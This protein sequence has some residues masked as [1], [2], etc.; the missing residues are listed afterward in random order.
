MRLVHGLRGRDALCGIRRQQSETAE[1]GI[2]RAAQAIVEPHF[3]GAGRQLVDGSTGGSVDD[4]VVGLLDENLLALGIGEQP[5]V[6][7]R[8]DDG[9]GER[10]AGRGNRVDRVGR[11]GVIVVG[12]F[13]DRILEAGP[14]GPGTANSHDQEQR[15]ADR[16]K[17]V[18]NIS[19]HWMTP[20]GVVEKA[21]TLPPSPMS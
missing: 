20:A 4:L 12:E 2:D 21:A 16:A 5:V 14:Q 3:G 8:A 11:V 1:R 13:C 10:I 15:K 9:K 18:M 7:Q 17:T 19:G 6:L